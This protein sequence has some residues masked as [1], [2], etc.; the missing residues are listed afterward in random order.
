MIYGSAATPV[1]RLWPSSS[2]YASRSFDGPQLLAKIASLP[3]LHQPGTVWAY[4]LSSDVLGLTIEAVAQQ[5]L[6]QVLQARLFAPLGMIDSGFIVPA[7]K[8]KRYARPLPRDPDT[9]A[10]Q[11]VAD[12]TRATKFECGGGCAVST[13]GDYLRFAQM[14]LEQGKLGPQRVL[15]RKSIELMTADHLGTAIE[16]PVETL[17]PTRA[18]Y[19]YGLGVGVRRQSGVSPFLGSPGDFTWSGANGTH[20]AVDPREQLVVVFMTHAPSKRAH[21]RQLLNSLVLA[22][23]ID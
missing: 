18:G 5:S 19:G 1:H 10:A 6:G 13:A 9:R 17:D 22:A 15:G 4:S 2:A 3:L 21:Y 16:N 23:I 12:S 11:T 20:F 7:D 14:L 8:V